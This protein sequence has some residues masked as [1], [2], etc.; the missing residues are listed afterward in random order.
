G[1]EVDAALVT[2]LID[3]AAGNAFYLEELIRSVAEGHGDRLPE[4]VIAMVQA[5]IEGL[6]VEARHV[7]RAASIFGE[8]FWRGGIVALLEGGS[9]QVDDWPEE[10]ERREL[11]TSRRDSRF[12]DEAE[13]TFRHAL[14]REAAYAMLTD[15]DRT[16][17]HRLAGGWLEARVKREHAANA[18]AV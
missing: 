4:T 7:L 17:G 16:V 10:L 14:V 3:R 11:I 1:K 18:E 13:Y 8:A 9:A 5:R 12:A 15:R 2:R 6:E